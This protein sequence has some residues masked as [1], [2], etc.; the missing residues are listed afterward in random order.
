M[1]PTC[2]AD[3]IGNDAI[4]L[5]LKQMVEKEAVGHALLFSGTEGIG[6]SLFAQVLCG[7]III[8]EERGSSQLAKLAAGIH[9]DI[10]HYRPEG[11]SGMHSIQSMREL[12]EEVYYPPFES[13]YKYFIIHDAERMLTYSANALLKTFE[14]PP[15]RTKILLISRSHHLLLPTILSRCTVLHFQPISS[16]AIQQYLEQKFAVSRQEAQLY[17]RL[18]HGSLA[19]AIQLVNHGGDKLRT[20]LLD[21]LAVGGRWSYKSINQLAKKLADEIEKKLGHIEEELRN[22]YKQAQLE[23]MSAQQKGAMEKELEGVLT[24]A[25]AQEFES[26]GRDLLSW[27]RDLR[28]LDLKGNPDLLIHA[29]YAIA[30]ARLLEQGGAIALDKVENAVLESRLALQRSTGLALTLENL[31]LKLNG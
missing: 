27:Y 2:F 18:A 17:S 4:K 30:L 25:T 19:K 6:K 28:L 16:V 1:I 12:C 26:I 13:A 21:A 11:K 10:H 29:D 24:M 9:P 14:E 15:P 7:S 3:L 22:T 20:L 23:K 5:Y 31:F 8:R